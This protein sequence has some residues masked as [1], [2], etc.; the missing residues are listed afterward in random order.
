MSKQ[1]TKL[2]S[3][4]LIIYPY[5]LSNNLLKEI[6]YKMGLNFS[7]TND[8]KKAT[9][10]IGLKKYLK[11]NFKLIEFCKQKNLQIYSTVTFSI[12]F[13]SL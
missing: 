5:S 12:S 8:I 9:L 11:Q 10:I 2:K 13:I 4:T 1:I 6:L 3:K 7:L